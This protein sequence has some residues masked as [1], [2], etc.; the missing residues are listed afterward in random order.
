MKD[1]E[2]RYLIDQF[3]KYASWRTRRQELPFVACTFGITIV[4]VFISLSSFLKASSP[5]PSLDFTLQLGAVT[6]IVVFLMWFTFLWFFLKAHREQD[7]FAECLVLLEDYRLKHKSLPDKALPDSITF[8]LIV[9][10]PEEVKNLLKESEP[11]PKGSG[12]STGDSASPSA[13]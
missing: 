8:K 6:L 3:N 12:N 1:D 7:A 11:S 10:K 9:E 13:R 5:V 4:A 2:A